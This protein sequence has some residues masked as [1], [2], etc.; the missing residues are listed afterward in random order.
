M[1]MQTSSGL[2]AGWTI[3]VR[4]GFLDQQQAPPNK[5]LVGGRRADEA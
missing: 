3:A 4:D 5:A 1:G 2:S